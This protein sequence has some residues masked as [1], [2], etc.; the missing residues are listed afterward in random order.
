MPTC[1]TRGDLRHSGLEDI[2]AKEVWKS[3][4]LLLV[5]TG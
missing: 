2:V 5:M 3:V 4:E 1:S